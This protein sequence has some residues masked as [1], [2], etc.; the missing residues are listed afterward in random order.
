M[1]F[2]VQARIVQLLQ[3]LCVLFKGWFSERI[4][5]YLKEKD[6]ALFTPAKEQN[7]FMK[8]QHHLRAI[9]MRILRLVLQKLASSQDFIHA[10]LSKR[11]FIY[12]HELQNP[13]SPG[14]G[15][16]LLSSTLYSFNQSCI[17]STLRSCFS[18]ETMLHL[19]YGDS[20]HSFKLC[21][22]ISNFLS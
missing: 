11:C 16:W 19:N 12:Q 15:K 22:P 1:P 10:F 3:K 13:W 20:A 14:I 21:L 4:A 5:V 7:R 8:N 18:F 9:T 6:I 17:K 2:L